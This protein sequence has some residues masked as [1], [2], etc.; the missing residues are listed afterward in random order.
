MVEAASP[1]HRPETMKRAAACL[2]G[3]WVTIPMGNES[4]DFFLK[5]ADERRPSTELCWEHAARLAALDGVRDAEPALA[6]NEQVHLPNQKSSAKSSGGEDEVLACA[7]SNELWSLEL[8]DVAAAWAL[9]PPSGGSQLGQG[10][11]IGHPDTGYRPHPE[12][13][14]GGHIRAD[15]G[16]NFEEENDNPIDPLSGS[17]P[18]HGTAT[19]SVIMS[20][21]GL[22]LEGAKQGVSGIAPRAELVPYRVS[23]SVVHFSMANVAQAIHAS[24]DAGCHVVSMSLGGPLSSNALERA[25]SRARDAGVILLAA[26]GNVWP[27]VVAPARLDDVIG[28]AA[29]NCQKKP[30]SKSASGREVNVTAP[31]ESVWR[32]QVLKNGSFAVAPSSGTSYAVASTA[33]ACALW[34]AFHG[35]DRLLQKYGP[36]GLVKVFE[37][38]LMASTTRPAGWDTS[39]FGTGIVNV[40]ALLQKALPASAPAE[41]APKQLAANGVS[42]RLMDRVTIHFPNSKPKSV[43]Q[44]V[45]ACL[46]I[47]EESLPGIAAELAFHLM[48]SPR[49]VEDVRQKLSEASSSKIKA[50]KQRTKSSSTLS[51]Y[52]ALAA[53]AS[54]HFREVLTAGDVKTGAVTVALNQP[55]AASKP[56][57]TQ[58]TTQVDKIIISSLGILRAKY[59]PAGMKRVLDALDMLIKADAKRGLVTRVFDLQDPDMLASHGLPGPVSQTQP[60][61]PEEAKTAIDAIFTAHRPD[62]LMILGGPDVVPYIPL[63]NPLPDDE[64]PEVPSDLPYASDRPYSTDAQVFRAP[65]RVVGRVPDVRGAKKPDFLLAALKQ[66]ASWQSQPVS[67]Y[68]K[69]PFGLS[70]ESWKRSTQLNMRQLFGQAA[71]PHLSPPA[72]PAWKAADLAPSSHFI[73][74]HGASLS[75]LYFGESENDA[76]DQPDAL[77]S[78]GLMR[79]VSPGTIIAAECCYGAE[80]YD[81]QVDPALPP[82]KPSI[83]NRYLEQG[84]WAFIGS[85]TIAYGPASGL[86]DADL[87]CHFFFKHI[88]A[89]AST[90]RAML[91]ARLDYVKKAG[92]MSRTEVKTLGQFVLLGDPSVQPVKIAAKTKSQ[93]KTVAK[94]KAGRVARRE[95]IVRESQVLRTSSGRSEPSEKSPDASLVAILLKQGGLAEDRIRVRKAMSFVHSSHASEPTSLSASK[96]K[97]KSSRVNVSAQ[98]HILIAERGDVK[99]TKIKNQ[100]GPMTDR[101]KKLRS[102]LRRAV[103]LIAREDGGHLHVTKLYP[104]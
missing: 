71:A 11:R 62:Y 73:N 19:A 5:P 103:V 48:N 30:W 94:G 61:S 26:A 28:V 85:T 57:A 23:S 95:S 14:S 27:F 2:P 16:R 96:S 43:R 68:L 35:R 69:T 79:K 84:A 64:D 83:A 39:R 72:G 60:P 80:L 66:A 90:G 89:G 40:R 10:I 6:S 78:D 15:L 87:I 97:A 32:A 49:L 50:A 12:L 25:V 37:Q 91:Q 56:L 31:G 9:T 70:T 101:Q 65:T 100:E 42:A 63:T 54:T 55:K 22:Q 33:G 21:R 75:P 41:V 46:G 3:A 86:G 98:H 76:N 47:G 8:M 34:L 93:G 4:A 88:L 38:L 18:G 20:P 51:R 82:E 17:S 67:V 74:C 1:K 36:R 92:R 59:K 58:P 53:A 81:P 99:D 45:S 13:I 52:P 104:H 29:C 102:F 24:I 77:H 7:V 44:A